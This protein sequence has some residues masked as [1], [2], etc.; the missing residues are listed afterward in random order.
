MNPSTSTDSE[1]DYTKHQTTK[2][3][4]KT[5]RLSSVNMKLKL[6]SF[7]TGQDCNCRLKC[8]E[9]VGDHK[10]EL[11]KRMNSL[12]SNDSINSYLT[13]LV[14]VIPVER[15]RPRV[16]DNEAK[17]R[18]AN[19]SYSVRYVDESGPIEV[20]VCKKAFMALHG[21]G[22]AKVAYILESLKKTGTSPMDQR[23]KH[24]N[25]KH[26]FS[27]D[28]KNKIRDHIKSLKTSDVR[29][30]LADT[31][32]KYLPGDLNVNKLFKMFK[33]HN[34]ECNVSYE[35][36]RT[37][38]C[39]E[40][41]LAFGYPR[42]DTCSQC[43]L[44][45]AKISCL[46]S[47]QQ[48]TTEN[49]T[50]ER[51]EIEIKDISADKDIHLLK[52][53]EWYKLK[54]K[55]KKNSRKDK[56][57]EA[58]VF[59]YAKNY[60][61]P[62]ITTN[63]VYYKRQLSIFLFNIHVLS[64][65]QS[66]FYI[67]PENTANKG[68]DEVCSFLHH[69]IYNILDPD[70]TDLEAFCDSCSGQNKNNIVFK[71]FHHV[72]VKEKR[73]N[74]VTCLF[75]VRGHSYNE[76]DKNSALIP[77]NYEAQLPEDWTEALRNCRQKPSPFQ[78]IEVEQEMVKEWGCHLEKVYKQQLGCK[79]RPIKVFKVHQAEPLF[80]NYKLMYSGPWKK[81]PMR[82]PDKKWLQKKNIDPLPIVNDGYFILPN[83]AYG[84]KLVY[85]IILSFF[86]FKVN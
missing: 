52:A 43:D 82:P 39:T 51:L 38:F 80:M 21:I 83:Q 30:S 36:Y 27:E 7:E 64:T 50:K 78:V 53:D 48:S 20:I 13:G 18:D 68:S 3:R 56:T 32:K 73:L 37:I 55:A 42:K 40:F 74:S 29:Y 63:D 46:K 16:D 1:D 77:Q 47:E 11:I 24:N 61:V 81:N 14:T 6:Q 4:K 65:G 69:F 59:D 67:Y 19:F 66:V 60:H 23:G 33:D 41:N 34:P 58:I 31:K 9:K 54:R 15:R 8:F 49:E 26:A 62:N 57:K 76:C 12:G 79:T 72:V 44:Y 2:K 71:F 25:H 28:T 35:S 75:P 5:G 45:A 84:G 10:F 17:F 22:R 70:V 86:S 85:I